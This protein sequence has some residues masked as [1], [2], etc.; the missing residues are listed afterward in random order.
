MSSTWNESENWSRRRSNKKTQFQDDASADMEAHFAFSNRVQQDTQL[1]NR[2]RLLTVLASIGAIGV[3][4]FSFL[5]ERSL[6]PAREASQV[7]FAS[8]GDMLIIPGFLCFG[9]VLFFSL[10]EL[11]KIYRELNDPGS[12]REKSRRRRS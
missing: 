7:G 12:Y 9:L 11:F 2:T 5:M 3:I 1:T 4:I 8:F 10:R 6:A